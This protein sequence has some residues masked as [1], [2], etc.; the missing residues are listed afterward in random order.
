MKYRLLAIVA[1]AAVI[2]W[3]KD[4]FT[5]NEQ[6]ASAANVT[7]QS[8]T[9]KQEAAVS[10]AAKYD[11]VTMTPDELSDRRYKNDHYLKNLMLDQSVQR[12]LA[13]TQ[14]LF[15][16]TPN[17][18]D[19]AVWVCL[20]KVLDSSPG[21]GEVLNYAFSKINENAAINFS[22]IEKVTKNL[23]G[24]EAFERGQLINLVNLMNLNKEEKIKF[25]GS[26]LSRHASF[27]QDGE[28]SA[29]AL[30]LTTALIMLKNT[31]AK[32]EDVLPYMRESLRLNTN[33]VLKNKLLTRFVSYFPGTAADLAEFK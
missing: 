30:N 1:I 16:D 5:S 21:Y 23:S 11:D 3:Q 29:D 13:R 2:Y 33:H 6:G 27:D 10:T 4:K 19:I 17:G 15:K 14:E 12:S 25:F 22:H 31:N 9:A 24:A 28:W 20:G 18:E 32:N 7:D 26:E 8:S